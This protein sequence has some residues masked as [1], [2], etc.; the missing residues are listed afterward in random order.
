MDDEKAPKQEF[1]YKLHFE[2]TLL[3][4]YNPQKLGIERGKEYQQKLRSNLLTNKKRR[5]RK[6]KQKQKRQFTE[7]KIGTD[8]I[9]TNNRRNKIKSVNS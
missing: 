6:Q 8:A 1:K 7:E 9:L 4:I 5:E 3:V 2:R